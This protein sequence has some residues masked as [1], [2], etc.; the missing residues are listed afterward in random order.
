MYAA[1]W[2]VLPGPTWVKAIEALALFLLV[3]FVLFEFVFPEVA[4]MLPWMD[5]AV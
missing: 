3:V 4:H 1:L 5:V 2:R